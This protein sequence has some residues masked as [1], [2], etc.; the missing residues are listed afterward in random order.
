MTT[1]PT[2]PEPSVAGSP[3]SDRPSACA[4]TTTAPG[5]HPSVQQHAAALS[6]ALSTLAEQMS[7]MEY[8]AEH[9]TCSETEAIISVL[10]LSGYSGAA[11]ALRNYH[12]AGDNEGYEEHHELYHQVT[13]TEP[14]ACCAADDGDVLTDRRKEAP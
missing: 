6:S 7:Q 12:A 1:P 14:G 9:L 4:P 2:L 13:E 5:Q 11:A 8:G 10:V 3:S